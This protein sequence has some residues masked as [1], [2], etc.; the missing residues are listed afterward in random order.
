MILLAFIKKRPRFYAKLFY[1]WSVINVVILLAGIYFFPGF[2]KDYPIFFSFLAYLT[3]IAWLSVISGFISARES[4]QNKLAALQEIENQ[5]E[6]IKQPVNEK[7]K[8]MIKFLYAIPIAIGW[9]L[10]PGN[11]LIAKDS[12]LYQPLTTI[13]YILLIT[14]V[15]AISVLS[16]KYSRE[17]RQVEMAQL[18][19]VAN[20]KW[21]KGATYLVIFGILALIAGFIF[22]YIFR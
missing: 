6:V 2:I 3:I 17:N 5:P 7:I 8:K 16:K 10:K 20:Q 9:F 11:H 19:S 1:W 15:L 21:S 13:A 22:I 18:E 4:A 12:S 14:S